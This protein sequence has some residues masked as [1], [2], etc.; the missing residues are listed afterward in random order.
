[1]E[2]RNG[3][4]GGDAPA[5]GLVFS[6]SGSFNLGT[7][8]RIFSSESGLAG[9][10]A[11]GGCSCFL[12]AERTAAGAG[13]GIP[14]SAAGLD[15]DLSSTPAS[16]ASAGFGSAAAFVPATG[17]ASAIVF[18]STTGFGSMAG[19]VGAN[20]LV[21]SL[22]FSPAF[23]SAFAAAGTIGDFISRLVS[24]AGGCGPAAGFETAAQALARPPG[25]R[26]FWRAKMR[27]QAGSLS[28][29]LS[30]NLTTAF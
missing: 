2:G 25:V 15:A 11:A 13:F 6:C 24:V 26:P 5:T 10:G 20:G 29:V 14:G 9:V 19:G 23:G 7:S 30:T 27:R 18:F 4:D 17:L 3:R 28:L 1:M 22:N 21:A 16:G 12:F 8:S